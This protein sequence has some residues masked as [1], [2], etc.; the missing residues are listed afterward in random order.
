MAKEP[1]DGLRHRLAEHL[2][3]LRAI[4]R[5]VRSDGFA[6]AYEAATQKDAKAIVEAIESGRRE[7]VQEFVRKGKRRNRTL[8]E[9]TVVELRDL[10]RHT[11]YVRDKEI[12]AA[13]A[14][15]GKA[16]LV[17]LIEKEMKKNE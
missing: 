8:D 10:V 13:E 3:D 15:S 9:M 5:T 11:Y 16:G 6:D 1:I 7:D 4:E 12:R 14:Q 2:N 17:R